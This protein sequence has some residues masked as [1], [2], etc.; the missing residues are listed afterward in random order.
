MG[1]PEKERREEMIKE[2][3]FQF[4]L[5]LKDMIFQIKGHTR[6]LGLWVKINSH[7]GTFSWYFRTLEAKRSYKN[8]EGGGVI[9]KGNRFTI[10]S[11]LSKVTSKA[12]RECLKNSNG[13]I[14]NL[15]I[16]I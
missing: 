9:F 4:F 3:I 12:N 5:E 11:D 13:M 8:R 2:F 1:I 15:E 16:D 6:Y 7:L 14:S 10:A